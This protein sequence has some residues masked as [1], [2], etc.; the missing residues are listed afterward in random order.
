ML[1]SGFWISSRKSVPFFFFLFLTTKINQNWFPLR[2]SSLIIAEITYARTTRSCY[3]FTIAGCFELHNFDSTLGQ[4]IASAEGCFLLK[5]L[6]VAAINDS[7]IIQS[8]Q[9][10]VIIQSWMHTPNRCVARARMTLTTAT[11]QAHFFRSRHVYGDR[12]SLPIQLY[13]VRKCVY[14][15]VK[16]VH[17]KAWSSIMPN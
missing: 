5:R 3:A 7:T 12:T 15:K 6:Y 14:G 2:S 8:Y 11:Q 9:H 16:N 4:L 13:V 10:K 17:W 1:H